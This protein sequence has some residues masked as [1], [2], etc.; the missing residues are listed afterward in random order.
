MSGYPNVSVKNTAGG[1]H[2]AYCRACD[3]QAII[4]DA[5]LLERFKRKHDKCSPSPTETPR[6][7][8]QR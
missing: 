1:N 5:G 7:G 4:F 8:G 2:D 6:R 3:T